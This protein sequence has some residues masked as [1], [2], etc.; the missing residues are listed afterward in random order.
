MT[1]EPVA[2]GVAQVEEL[3]AGA[4][5]DLR[6]GRLGLETCDR[7]RHVAGEAATPERVR[8]RAVV[9]LGLAAYAEGDAPEAILRL[10]DAI[11]G[12][13]ISCLTHPDVFSALG[14][15][16]MILGAPERAAEL[17][18][19]C[20]EEVAAAGPDAS[21]LR[22]RY[23]TQLSYSLCELGDPQRARAALSD[24]FENTRSTTD[25]YD[26]VRAH[27]ALGNIAS[28]QTRASE[29]IRHY[30][31]AIALLEQTEDSLHLARAHVNCAEMM[32]TQQKALQASP[33]LAAAL[34][35]YGAN[36]EPADLGVVR[37][38]QARQA[39]LLGRPADTIALAQEALDLFGLDYPQ[40]QAAA[41]KALAHGFESLGQTASAEQAYRQA[42]TILA[43]LHQ[44]HALNET[45]RD[46]ARLLN[47]QGRQEEAKTILERTIADRHPTSA[48][49]RP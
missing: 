47:R 19:C 11:A 3:L 26:L 45:L 14:K 28:L 4:E 30:L 41:L 37:A 6:L 42:S 10:T 8:V 25:T 40:F 39:C 22:L 35:L 1:V 12:P 21:I 23:A 49:H 34:T 9:V 29:A 38:Q 46:W 32:L 7:L 44:A 5:L 16:Y 43:E 31:A 27:W 20:L 36:P 17:F 48:A 24:A 18:E 33:H 2:T 15:A 13:D